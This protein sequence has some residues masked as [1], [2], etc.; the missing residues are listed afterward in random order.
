MKQLW[1]YIAAPLAGG[2]LAGILH[3]AGIT[4]AD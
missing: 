1:L 4:R 3:A 2:A